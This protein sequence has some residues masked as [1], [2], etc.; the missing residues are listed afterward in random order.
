MKLTFRNK[1]LERRLTVGALLDIQAAGVDFD[2]AVNSEDSIKNIVANLLSVTGIAKIAYAIFRRDL[3]AVPFDQFA[4]ELEP[5]QIADLRQQLIDELDSFFLAGGR[6]DMALILRE[7][8]QAGS[9]LAEQAEQSVEP[10]VS[11]T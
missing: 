7:I 2:A 5:E 3:K 9:K 4:D 1:N 6:P 10:A 11:T 8:K